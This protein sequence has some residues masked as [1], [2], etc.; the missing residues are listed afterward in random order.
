VSIELV[1]LWFAGLYLVI[2]EAVILVIVSR[3]NP[4]D[5]PQITRLLGDWLRMPPIIRRDRES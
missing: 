5:L 2:R 3:A 4:K 1:L